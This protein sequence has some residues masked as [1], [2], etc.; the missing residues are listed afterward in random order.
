MIV[1][2]YTFDGKKYQISR[3]AVVTA[4]RR[5]DEEFGRGSHRR[6]T[7]YFV[8]YRGKAYPPKEILRRLPQW[9]ASRFSGGEATNQVFRGL[10]FYVGKGKYPGRLPGSS[11]P[12]LSLNALKKKLMNQRWSVFAP[13]FPQG[14]A[15]QY[16]GVYLF[17]WSDKKLEGK[18]ISFDDIFYV[19]SSC[20]ALQMRLNQFSQGIKRNCCHSA[21]MRFYERWR[22]RSHAGQSFYVAALSIPCETRKELRTEKDIHKMGRVAELEYA[23]LAEVKKHTGFEP[24]LNRK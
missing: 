12:L 6:G 13:K 16:P 18:R 10:E 23:M 9:S 21:A 20:T 14:D 7:K 1:L 3:E 11:A 15:G 4:M 19:G 24:L 5:F 2:S 8:W 22:R 17:A